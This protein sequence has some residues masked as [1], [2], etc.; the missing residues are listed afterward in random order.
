ME[1]ELVVVVVQTAVN[2]SKLL[3]VAAIFARSHSNESHLKSRAR[4]ELS[5]LLDVNQWHEW[6]GNPNTYLIASS[7]SVCTANHL[8]T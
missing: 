1:S 6:A 3:L 5:T 8:S 7:S 4:D 2:T